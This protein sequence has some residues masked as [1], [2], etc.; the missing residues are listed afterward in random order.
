MPRGIDTVS[1]EEKSIKTHRKSFLIPRPQQKECSPFGDCSM[2][3]RIIQNGVIYES[4][5]GKTMLSNFRGICSSL[6]NSESSRAVAY[7]GVT[8]YPMLVALGL[9]P[10]NQPPFMI[11][12]T[13]S[14]SVSHFLAPHAD[15]FNAMSYDA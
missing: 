8:P 11:L 7:R 4:N 1:R 3:S 12:C 9:T 10:A 13:L 14:D 6:L 15:G 5:I 2:A